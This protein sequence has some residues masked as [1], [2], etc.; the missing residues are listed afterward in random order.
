MP[1]DAKRLRK[2]LHSIGLCHC[3]GKEPSKP[4]MLIEY[5]RVLCAFISNHICPD[6]NQTF[7][8]GRKETLFESIKYSKQRCTFTS[9]I[10]EIH[11]NSNK[12]NKKQTN[13]V[14]W[15]H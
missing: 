2:F 7:C 5:I 4:L 3:K 13:A 15:I 11:N 12:E 1:D 10:M 14:I 8:I 9:K 6:K